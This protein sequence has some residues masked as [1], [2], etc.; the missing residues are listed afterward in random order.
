MDRIATSVWEAQSAA[1]E[2][3]SA[4]LFFKLSGAGLTCHACFF[5]PF[6]ATEEEEE[7]EEEDEEVEEEAAA[8]DEE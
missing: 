2:G 7:D 3:V 1:A 5:F 6:A 4:K 8:D